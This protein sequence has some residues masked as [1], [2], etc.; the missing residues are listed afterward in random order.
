M[1]E[2]KTPKKVID[3]ELVEKHFRAGLLSLREIC[4]AVNNAVTEGAIR[5]RAKKD[6]W[7]RDLSAKIQQKAAEKVERDAVRKERVRT[8]STQLTAADEKDVVEVNANQVAAVDIANRSDL[9]LVLDT[10]RGMAQEIAA[11]S[12]PEIAEYLNELADTYDKSGPNSSG[13]WVPDKENELYRYII[14]LAGR[15]KMIKD[16]AGAHGVYIPLQRKIFGLDA[17]KKQ[18]TELDELLKKVH[19]ERTAA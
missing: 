11:L 16:L 19:A 6:G 13:R 8:G 2:A 14:S 4:A 12:R 9:E 5:K 18:S 3:W 17:E 1:T 7:S 10:Q 15:V